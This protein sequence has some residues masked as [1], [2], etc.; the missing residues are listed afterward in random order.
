MNEEE[1]QKLYNELEKQMRTRSQKGVKGRIIDV[2][3]GPL[4]SF[5]P[6]EKL[7]NPNRAKKQAIQ[8]TVET[9]EGYTV[10][11]AMALSS[12]PN[13]NIM[14][15]YNTYGDWPRKGMEIMLRYDESTGFWRVAL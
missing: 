13:A 4:S 10:R 14:R 7:R 15:F 2:K 5:I 1:L 6:P 11:K 9:P 12:H 8:I 3:I